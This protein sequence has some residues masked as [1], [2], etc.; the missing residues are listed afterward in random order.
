MKLIGFLSVCALL[1]VPS[2]AQAQPS[3]RD[4]TLA[5]HHELKKESKKQR[6]LPKLVLPNITALSNA[7]SKADRSV[8]KQQQQKSAQ[9]LSFWNGRG[10]WLRATRHEKCWEVPWQRSC[11]LARASFRLHNTLGNL[12]TRRLNTELPITNDWVTAVHLIQRV[13]PGTESWLLSCSAAEGGHGRWV[14]YGGGSYYPGYEYTDAVGNWLQ[15]RW[16]TFKGHYRNGLA[17]LRARGFKID[18]PASTDVQAWLMPMGAAIAGGWA[19]WSGN[20]NS[21]WSASWG[22]GC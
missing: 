4:I 8:L 1:L 15:Y 18:M 5:V 21:H 19:R 17:S 9:T 12:A 3:D 7:L 13:F 10:K 6:S 22:N 16:S 11:T 20:D 2:A 14:R